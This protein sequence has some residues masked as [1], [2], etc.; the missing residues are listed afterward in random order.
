MQLAMPVLHPALP[1]HVLLRPG[2]VLDGPA[3]ARLVELRVGQIWIAYPGLEDLVRFVNPEAM[4]EQRLMARD[5][6]ATL[7]RVSADAKADLDFRTYAHAVRSLLQKLAHSGEAQVLVTDLLGTEGPLVRHSATVCFLSLIMGL[8]LE[9]YLIAQRPKLAPGHARAVDN[10]GVAALLHDLGLT[11]LEP[12]TIRRHRAALLAGVDQADPAYEAHVRTGYEMVRGR[13]EP[14]ASAAILQHHQRYDG[15][16][17]PVASVSAGPPRGLRGSEIHVFARI[18]AVA[19]R[20]DEL[21]EPVSPDG[22]PLP[23]PPAVRVLRRL[24]GEA[25]RRALDP[26]AMKGLIH[27]VPPFPPGT[28]VT[29]TDERDAVV[30]SF[31]PLTPCRPV[32][33][34]IDLKQAERGRGAEALGET[35]DLTTREDVAIERAEGERVLEDLFEA[36]D[37]WEFDLRYFAAP[38]P[39]RGARGAATSAT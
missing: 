1:G 35:I 17:Y 37:A 10:L 33:R 5:L 22:T 27:C 26:V 30:T 32:V 18:L 8:K 2:F 7:D 11:R 25:R 23:R 12:E 24:L 3:L 16:G 29:L 19:D 14:T 20:F 4:E 31:A 28:I 38:K 9:A 13:I 39:A 6:S 15:R 36:A 34:T 21:R